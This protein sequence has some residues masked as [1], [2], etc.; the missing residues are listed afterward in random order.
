MLIYLVE[1]YRI[2]LALELVEMCCICWLHVP[3]SMVLHSSSTKF[4]EVCVSNM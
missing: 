4:V 3:E 1:I 2:T